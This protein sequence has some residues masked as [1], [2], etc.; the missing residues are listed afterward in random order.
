MRRCHNVRIRCRGD[1]PLNVLATFYGA[2]DGC[3]IWDV[4]STLL[5]PTERRYY[6]VA[7]TSC[8]RVGQQ[9]ISLAISGTLRTIKAECCTVNPVLGCVWWKTTICFV[10][11]LIHVIFCDLFTMVNKLLLWLF[12]FGVV[13]FF[14]LKDLLLSYP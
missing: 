12:S 3:S 2:V 6:D 9:L 1:V 8:C 14:L 7:T 11:S 4:T 10:S 13:C 5:G